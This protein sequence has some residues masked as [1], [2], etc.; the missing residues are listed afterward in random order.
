MLLL[1]G[2]VEADQLSAVVVADTLELFAGDVKVGAVGASFTALTVTTIVSE[3]VFTP[4]EAVN[5]IVSWPLKSDAALTFSIFEVWFI[6]TFTLLL[7]K[8]LT[9][10]SFICV[11]WSVMN[12][13]RLTVALCQSSL[14]VMSG[15]PL[16]IG[17]N[18]LIVNVR[19]WELF[20]FPTSS[21]EVTVS[22]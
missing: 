7:P 2:S 8:A 14:K 11:S 17:A 16:T 9:V 6:F 19:V 1:S 13:L 22:V 4:S 15:I 3:S 18:E 5:I 20:A 12:W 10:M 21:N